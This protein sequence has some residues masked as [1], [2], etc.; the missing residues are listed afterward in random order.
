M[1]TVGNLEMV[2]LLIANGPEVNQK[3]FR[4]GTALMAAAV[5]GI[6]SV[7]RY[8]FSKEPM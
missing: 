6:P 8:Y 3:N 1:P 5:D 4:G 2:K 7:L